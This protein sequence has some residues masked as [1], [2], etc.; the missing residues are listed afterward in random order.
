M[1]DQLKILTCGSVDDGKSTLIGHLLYDSKLLYVDQEKTL[2]LDS[3]IQNNNE[4]DY[5]LLL[6]GLDEEREQGITIDVSYRY[7]NT[8]KR[9]F[10]VLDTP[11]HE[12]YT[13]NM[14]VG[15]SQADLA[16]LLVDVSKGLL[17]QTKR[18]INICSMMGIKDYVV[19]I[20]KMDLINYNKNKFNDIKKQ[21]KEFFGNFL[22]SSLKII[23]ISA[24]KGDNIMHLSKN[25]TWYK[26]QPLMPYLETIKI[27]KNEAHNKKFIFP[28]QRV[29]RPNQFFR[30]FQGN[31]SS[32]KIKIGD[33]VFCLPSREEAKVQ[34]LYKLDK[35]V[36]SISIGQPSTI[37]L[38]REID[39]SRGCVLTNDTNICVTNN[40][41]ATLLW[42]DIEEVK[43]NQAYYLVVGTKNTLCYIKKINYK[44]D[45]NDNSKSDK[46]NNVYRNDIINCDIEVLEKIS[47]TQFEYNKELGS[48]ILINR[49][50]NSTSCCGIIK[51]INKSESL[52]Y[53]S[54]TITPGDRQKL[55]YQKP[56]TIWFTGLSCSGKSTIANE[57]DRILNI[58]GYHT[59]LL[60][61]DNIRFGLNKDLSFSEDDR[62]E[63]IR[64]IAEV[65]KLMNDAGLICITSFISPLE[66][67]RSMAK[68]IIGDN[69]VL[70]YINTPIEECIKRDKKGLYKRAYNGEISNF[71]GVNSPFEI[72]ENPNIILDNKNYIECAEKIYNYILERIEICK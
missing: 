46:F 28:V 55:L 64:R 13:K 52:F 44:I 16:I 68:Q 6:D 29:S 69:F 45:I 43:I 71:T 59:M 1:K 3:K 65:S 9:N 72:P 7:F 34:E 33:S 10:I 17:P 2:E 39:V 8:N 23:P 31:V 30:G 22:Y 26:E 24:T 62:I 57:L 47:V 60:D 15:A 58:N 12:E 21:I 11:G 56:I 42:T 53:Q 70:V 5:S 67:N 27:T 36:D 32:G 38:D 40:I 14:A 25:M 61:G 49:L 20:N 35:K 63:N 19:V 18:H 66:I 37:T 50:T 48:L 41:N 54:T 51:R 4:L